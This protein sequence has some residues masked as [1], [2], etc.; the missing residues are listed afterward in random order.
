M[1]PL[2]WDRIAED[3]HSEVISPF[4]RGVVNPLFSKLDAVKAA[5]R[6]TV[7]DIGC[8]RGEILDSLAEKFRMVY[9]IDFSPRMIRFAK[10]N[11]SMPNIRFFVTDM[12]DLSGFGKRFDVAITANSILPPKVRDVERSLK[13]VHGTLKEGGVFYGIFP[14]MGSIL[15]QAFLIFDDRV[16]RA[17]N[18][19]KAL[20]ATKR[21]MERRKYNFIKGTFEHEGMAQKLYYDFELKIRLRKAGFKNVTLS[22]VLY[23]W[24]EGIS[25]FVQFPG[26]PRMWDWFVSARK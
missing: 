19:R 17:D 13:S 1:R 4:Q 10:R 3:Y 12:R 21:L 2:E 8:G 5:K 23:P 15:Y 11:S 14:S 16:H 20:I 24:D 25:D 9:A 7:A 18:E 26:M 22:K 6:K